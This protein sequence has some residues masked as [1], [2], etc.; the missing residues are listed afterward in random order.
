MVVSD[1]GRLQIGEISIDPEDAVTGETL[2]VNLPLSNVGPSPVEVVEARCDVLPST[3]SRFT[4]YPIEKDRTLFPMRVMPSEIVDITWAVSYDLPEGV[5]QLEV[6]LKTEEGSTIRTVSFQV[7]HP[8]HLEILS[9]QGPPTDRPPIHLEEPIP[10]R[11]EYRN[12]GDAPSDE[13]VLSAVERSSGEVLS[14]NLPSLPAREI[15]EVTASLTSA[16]ADFQWDIRLLPTPTAITSRTRWSPQKLDSHLSRSWDLGKELADGEWSIEFDTLSSQ[17]PISQRL[18]E[19]MNLGFETSKEAR[20]KEL[21]AGDLDVLDPSQA[22]SVVDPFYAASLFN[23][24]W[25][26]G[27]SEIHAPQN[28]QAP[29]FRLRIPLNEGPILARLAPL[30]RKVGPDMP[31]FTLDGDGVS[32]RITPENSSFEGIHPEKAVVEMTPPGLPISLEKVPGRSTGF[33]GFELTPLPVAFTPV[34]ELPDSGPWRASAG[35]EIPKALHGRNAQSEFRVLADGKDWTP[36]LPLEPDTPI[37]SNRIQLRAWVD[38]TQ[39]PHET[40]VRSIGFSLRRS[41][42]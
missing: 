34:L 37:D 36:W 10:F 26:V 18:F 22:R 20:K 16:R 1:P 23:T 19:P 17:G 2:F 21:F 3:G 33:G 11:I 35:M 12:Q 5:H 31:N 9:I 14:V 7:A 6:T 8:P 40:Y 39:T 28:W 27:A 13:L 32:F 29:S 30:Y 42:R 4:V 41:T 25:W 24:G 38:P 15:G